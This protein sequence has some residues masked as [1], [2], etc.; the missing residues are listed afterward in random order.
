[1]IQNVNV[2]PLD[3]PSTPTNGSIV[4]SGSQTPLVSSLE[5]TKL[6]NVQEILISCYEHG[7][8]QK[9]DKR[10]QLLPSKV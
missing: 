8:L 5:T 9:P 7:L 10:C 3:K 1:M 4:H 2:I 6:A